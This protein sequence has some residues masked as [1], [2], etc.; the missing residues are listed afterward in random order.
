MAILI[1]NDGTVEPFGLKYL[2]GSSFFLIAPAIDH[3]ETVQA[4]DGEA[5]FPTMF[6]NG[7]YT[8]NMATKQGMSRAE[9]YT[10]KTELAAFF[11]A[12]RKSWDTLAWEFASDKVWDI[13]VNGRVEFRPRPGGWFEVI[14]PLKV[15]P[16]KRA[17]STE[18][19]FGNEQAAVGMGAV[20]DPD[21]EDDI[22][23]INSG[24]IET[25]IIIEITGPVTDPSVT[26][27]DDELAYTGII[28]AGDK[29][30]IDTGAKTCKFNTNNA[31]INYNEKWPKLQ[32]GSTILSM[33]AI[34]GAVKVS[35][36]NKWL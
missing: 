29:V 19:S 4:A 32:P 25:P 8:L 6:A 16:H 18:A 23:L 24:T 12:F 22:A 14:L 13:K 35:W 27:G 10:K 33:P 7:S 3:D 34:Q 28:S 9:L 21:H 26:I 31:I 15:K 30:T 5:E 20:Y 2:G 17:A 36:F 1:K 11:N